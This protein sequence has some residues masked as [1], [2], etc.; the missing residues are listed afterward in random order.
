MSVQPA[1]L[2]MPL[3]TS[4]HSVSAPH[5]SLSAHSH[6]SSGVLVPASHGGRAARTRTE[7]YDMVRCDGESRRDRPA[8]QVS[9]DA[10]GAPYPGPADPH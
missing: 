10:G 2:L 6:V 5:L 1:A 8:S 9:A 7:G 4:A 3:A